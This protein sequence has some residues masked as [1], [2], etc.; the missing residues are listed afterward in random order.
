MARKRLSFYGSSE[1]TNPGDDSRSFLFLFS[2]ITADLVG[3]SE[4]E[5]ATT[6][7]RLLVTITNN[8]LPA[9]RLTDLQLV[10]V[11]FEIGRRAVEE[12]VRACTLTRETSVIVS[13]RSHPHDCPFD[14]SRI[15]EPDGAVCEVD[16]ER[17]MGFR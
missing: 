1:V 16:E 3:S 2:M 7:H 12:K 15:A 9:W 17:R 11:L 8:R 6:K 14:P 5:Q 4:E 13:T 10:R